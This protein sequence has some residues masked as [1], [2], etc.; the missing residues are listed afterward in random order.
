[1]KKNEIVEGV[2]VKITGVAS[3]MLEMSNFHHVKDFNAEVCIS[4][5]LK[6]QEF[7]NF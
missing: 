3:E 1:M 5:N 6:N 7:Q 2:S 4:S